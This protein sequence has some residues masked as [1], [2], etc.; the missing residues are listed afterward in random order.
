MEKQEPTVDQ[1]TLIIC[2][3]GVTMSADAIAEF[4]VIPRA[5]VQLK[6][7]TLRSPATR[8]TDALPPPLESIAPSHP[9]V[10]ELTM[11]QILLAM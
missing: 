4:L 7:D 9:G 8:G 3:V 11:D 5:I 6:G 2:G 1:V 10:A